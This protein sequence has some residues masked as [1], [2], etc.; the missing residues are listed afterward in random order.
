MKKVILANGTEIT[1][2]TDSTTSNEIYVLRDTYAL[3]GAVRDLFTAEN[4]KTIVVKDENDVTITVGAD[5]VLIDGAELSSAVGGVICAIKTRVKS[6][7]E[8]MQD[9]IAELQE[10]VIEE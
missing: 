6:E 8:K 1:N 2:C 4:A 3:A 10:L 9:E 5:L 7:V